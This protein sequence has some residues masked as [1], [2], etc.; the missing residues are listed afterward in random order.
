M[1]VNVIYCK[2]QTHQ[3]TFGCKMRFFLYIS[4]VI[5][6]SN[7]QLSQL[8][9]STYSFNILLGPGTAFLFEELRMIKYLFVTLAS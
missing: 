7:A 8:N 1:N 9:Q 6:R 5:E 2:R 4:T 3:G